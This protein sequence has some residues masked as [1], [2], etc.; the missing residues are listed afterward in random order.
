MLAVLRC[1]SQD[2][3]EALPFGSEGLWS[4]VMKAARK[5]AALEDILAA[6]K[7]KRY[8][9]TRLKRMLLCLYL[10]LTSEDLQRPVP[11]LRVLAFN[12]RGRELLRR[13]QSTSCLPLVSGPVPKTPEAR[14]YFALECRATDLYGLFAAPGTVEP[15]QRERSTPPVFVR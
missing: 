15:N 8:A 13:L 2:Q 9:Y 3:F 10:G 14:A 12:D 7:S 1:A 11:Y 5:E 4:K 6:C